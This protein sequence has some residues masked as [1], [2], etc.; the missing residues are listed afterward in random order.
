M[1]A[2]EWT[3]HA[4]NKFGWAPIDE[5]KVL[6]VENTSV[7]YVVDETDKAI[8]LAQSVGHTGRAAEVLTII[9]SCI[10]KKKEL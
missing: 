6:P 7:G 10:V 2:I 5:I 3:D 9:K 8:A 1:F 4:V